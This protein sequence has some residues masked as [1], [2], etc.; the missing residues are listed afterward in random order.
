MKKIQK[1][2]VEIKERFR[3]LDKTLKEEQ[4]GFSEAEK[5][6]VKS[7]EREQDLL[8]LQARSESVVPE[9]KR[10]Y[11][12]GFRSIVE[13]GVSH[14][15][16]RLRDGGAEATS[17]AVAPMMTEDIKNG[18]LMPVTIGEIV[19]PLRENLIFDK[20]GI[21][22]PVGCQGMYEWPVVEAV[23]AT[24]AGEGVKVDA[25]KI[26]LSKVA[27]SS[28]RIAVGVSATRESM[29][30]SEGKLEGI[31][32]EQLPLAI[33]E[34]LNEVICSPK[35]V[36]E[37]CAIAGPFVG[38][39][40]TAIGFTYKELNKE[41]AK[42]LAKGVKSSNMVWIMSEAT[43]AELEALPKDTGSG[44]MV[45]ENDKLCGLPIFCS[46][47]IGEDTIGLGDFTYQVCNQFGD[48]YLTVDP[49][50]GAD[51]NDV[52]FWLNANFGTAT[53][54]KEVFALLKKKA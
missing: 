37:N 47:A 13:S 45:V 35:K 28:Q 6:E 32:R 9:T 44:I 48:F 20:I 40:P 22:M 18:G 41:K 10:T 39:T 3:E 46:S 31:I 12:E 34:T 36:T 1:R 33:A 17:P 21:R 26:D 4:R 38:L 53:L 14:I 5:E 19:N 7:L 42:L 16:M 27:V 15:E 29:F 49:Y 43:K 2:L 51:S 8:I 24:I 52:K 54:R 25:K 23:K 30:N 11:K 50:T